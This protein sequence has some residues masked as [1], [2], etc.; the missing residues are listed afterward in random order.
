VQTVRDT[1]DATKL[2]ATGL[3]LALVTMAAP[4]VASDPGGHGPDGGQGGFP[5]LPDQAMYGICNAFGHAD[6]NAT[7]AAPFAWLSSAMCEDTA[8][9]ADEHG[10]EDRGAEERAEH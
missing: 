6:E 5:G 9:P 1:M 2:T 7:T 8:H 3:A 10:G 4:A